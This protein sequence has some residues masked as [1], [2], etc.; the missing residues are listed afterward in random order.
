MRP[1]QWIGPWL[2]TT[3]TRRTI[4]TYT[5]DRR[6]GLGKPSPVQNSNTKRIAMDWAHPSP[7]LTMAGNGHNQAQF[8]IE[9]AAGTVGRR[10]A[11][12]L[13]KID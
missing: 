6:S 10:S 8:I 7:V 11:N 1:T 4:V 3:K 9:A 13:H 5:N 12:M 2:P